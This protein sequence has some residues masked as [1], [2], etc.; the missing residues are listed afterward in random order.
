MSTALVL[1]AE[2]TIYAVGALRAAWL[3]WL[4][5]C[6][7]AGEPA[8]AAVDAHAVAEVDAAG[9]QLIAALARSAGQ[10]GLAWQLAD[11]SPVLRLALAALGCERLADNL[12][13]PSA[14]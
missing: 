8:T 4:D 2:L 14:P 11:P 9:V 10:R 3:D 7:A 5:A 1:P 12:T 13:P 6:V